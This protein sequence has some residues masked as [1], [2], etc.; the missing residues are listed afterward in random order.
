MGSEPRKLFEKTV[1]VPVGTEVERREKEEGEG[2]AARCHD[3]VT[4]EL[5]KLNRSARDRSVT[6]YDRKWRK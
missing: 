5:P 4:P 6:G 2:A 3:H 1:E